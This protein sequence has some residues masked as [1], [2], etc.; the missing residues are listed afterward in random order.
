[1]K[2]LLIFIS[3]ACICGNIC[4][5][6]LDACEDTTAS[7][8]NGINTNI[9]SDIV[10]LIEMKIMR[11]KQIQKESSDKRTID[12]IDGLITGYSD[13]LYKILYY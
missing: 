13:C 3:L 8:E 6:A 11:L 5:N 12:F 9:S 1:M 4:T 7:N 10:S 2:K